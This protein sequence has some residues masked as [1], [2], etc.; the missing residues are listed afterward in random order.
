MAITLTAAGTA[1]P[2]ELTGLSRGDEL[3]WSEGTGRAATDGLMVGSVVAKKQTW[4]ATWAML[5]QAQYD[6]VRAIPKGFFTLLV[7]DGTSTVA[8][9]TC[10]RSNVDGDLAG[11]FGGTTYWRNVA[12]QFTER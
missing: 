1:L 11:T 12:V 6:V 5:T 9:I 2:D 10:Y 8:S 7:K 4:T 3:L